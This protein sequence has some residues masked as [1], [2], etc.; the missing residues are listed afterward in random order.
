MRGAS[1]GRRAQ[2]QRQLDA[3]P[4]RVL[5]GLREDELRFMA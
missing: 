4:S 2:R 1:A 5:L 3:R